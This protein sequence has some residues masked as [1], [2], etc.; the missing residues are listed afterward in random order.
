MVGKA[1]GVG[2]DMPITS[3]QLAADILKILED[4]VADY[5]EDEREEAKVAILNAFSSEM[6]VMPMKMGDDA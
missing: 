6:F 5:P 3:K 4:V 2:A 1:A